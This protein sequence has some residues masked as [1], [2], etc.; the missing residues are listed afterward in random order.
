MNKLWVGSLYYFLNVILHLGVF[1]VLFFVSASDHLT[2]LEY[3]A[4]FWQSPE[5][6]ET[7]IFNSALLIANLVFAL[8][9]IFLAPRSSIILIIMA[10]IAWLGLIFAYQAELVGLLAYA[11]GAIHLSI[12][13]YNH[14]KGKVEV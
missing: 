12:F 4:E 7:I 13:S 11:A 8:G 5:G 14:F 1:G 9:I 6:R 3:I 2:I 10:V